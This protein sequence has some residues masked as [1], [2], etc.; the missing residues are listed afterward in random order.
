MFVLMP[1]GADQTALQIFKSGIHRSHLAALI[2]Y[3]PNDK[4]LWQGL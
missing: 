4:V 2:L 1:M 3:N